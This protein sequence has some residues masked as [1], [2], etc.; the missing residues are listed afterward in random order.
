MRVL[1]YF[2]NTILI[3][4][5]LGLGLGV[6]L[7][8]RKV[9]LMRF[10]PGILFS[11][12]FLIVI[13]GVAG[14]VL[15]FTAKEDFV[16]N[17]LSSFVKADLGSYVVLVFFY[18][19]LTS[20]MVPLGQ[21]L[22]ERMES[23][24]PII[25]YSI[26][27]GGS[28]AGIIGFSLISLLSLPPLIWFVIAM[29]FTLP[30]IVRRHL[31][32]VAYFFG[33]IALILSFSQPS[34]VWSPYYKISFFPFLLDSG[35]YVGVNVY[36]NDESH[37]QALNLDPGFSKAGFLESRR[38]LYDLPYVFND[39]GKV[40]VIG[41]GTGN[42]VAAALRN[43][44]SEVT[45]VEIDSEILELGMS[46]HPERPYDD[47]RVKLVVDDARSFL[48]RDK[49]R[50]DV[51]A[52][53]FLDSHMLFS[54]MSNVRLDNYVYTIESL[55]N[56]RSHLAEDGVVA[57][58]FTVHEKWIADKIYSMLEEVF[59]VKPLV[60]QGDSDS[61]GTVFIV[62]SDLDVE[63]V[64]LSYGLVDDEIFSEHSLREHGYS[65]PYLENISGFV[66]GDVFSGDVDLS[67]DDWPYLYMK[68]RFIPSNYLKFIF[69]IFL[70]S[71]ILVGLVFKGSRRLNLHFFFLGAGFM[72]LETKS[73]T[74]MALLFGSTW[75]VNSVV[76]SSI[77]SVA[78]IAN[79]LVLKQKREHVNAFYVL[80]F[81]AL[82]FNY[83]TPVRS[84]LTGNVLLQLVVSS[85]FISLPIFFA[86]MIFATS[87]KKTVNI[88][89][90]F[91]SNLLGV[92]A[93]GLMEYTSLAWGLKTL[94]IISAIVYLLSLILRRR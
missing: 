58:T 88:S 56:V 25:A 6:G 68:G 14:V 32:T 67:V 10:F 43:G 30:F 84:L 12:T 20:V 19:L 26:N 54:S 75:I 21:V 80:L 2:T 46:V 53:G 65:W 83:V 63:D 93:G 24:K 4:C 70:A 35:E 38:L 45:A 22:G 7:A 33:V 13:M 5:F 60:Y 76:F 15:P 89:Q 1:A 34:T 85:F 51:I 37:Q 52:F 48:R 3:A 72:L 61:W 9:R 59:R 86:A 94:Y 44:V 17:G 64:F 39:P 74:E 71:A 91:G 8:G 62:G 27:L 79:F 29:V 81:I 55:E 77:L 73:I 41:A 47:S 16:W 11:V 49:E 78:L 23:F 18:L 66:K 57:I 50:Y 87:F 31:I 28:L 90:A 42:D 82:A 40:L 92:V 69:L 36:V